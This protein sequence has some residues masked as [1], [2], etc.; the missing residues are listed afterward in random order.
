MFIRNELEL[1]CF[2]RSVNF[3]TKIYPLHFCIVCLLIKR[4]LLI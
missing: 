2:Y 3:K 1:R 4:Y